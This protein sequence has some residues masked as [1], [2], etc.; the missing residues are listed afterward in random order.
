MKNWQTQI[1]KGYLDLCV[2]LL[3]R[4]EKKMYGFQL[5]SSLTKWGI[6]IQEGTLYPML[7]RMTVEGLLASNW[8]MEN[9]KGH[10]RKFYALTANGCETLSAMQKEFEGMYRQYLE[11]KKG[12][13]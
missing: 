8:D 12:G 13:Q 6:E 5:L 1:K 7:N 4:A 9:I 10:P 11:V 3:I 2:L